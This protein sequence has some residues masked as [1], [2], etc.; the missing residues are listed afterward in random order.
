MPDD[1]AA[2]AR[3]HNNLGIVLSRTGTFVGAVEQGEK[4]EAIWRDLGARQRVAYRTGWA[5]SLG[6]V[7]EARNSAGRSQDAVA[8]A[9]QAISLLHAR[10][11]NYAICQ[12][13]SARF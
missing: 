10:A 3:S 13:A 9:E 12:Q 5:V 2:L 1:R 4:A 6:N 8:A 11:T 7:A